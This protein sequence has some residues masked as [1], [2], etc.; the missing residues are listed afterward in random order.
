[1]L[2]IHAHTDHMPIPISFQCQY[3]VFSGFK[4]IAKNYCKAIPTGYESLRNHCFGSF[5]NRH[6]FGKAEQYCFSRVRKSE[7]KVFC[8]EKKLRLKI[9]LNFPHVKIEDQQEI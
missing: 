8:H 9:S 7:D 2:D 5:I 3:H 1:M 4:V 6:K